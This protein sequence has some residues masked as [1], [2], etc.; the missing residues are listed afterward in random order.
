MTNNY[1]SS[2]LRRLGA[3]LALLPISVIA[4]GQTADLQIVKSGPATAAGGGAFSYTLVLDNNGPNAANNASF[5]DTL[6]PGVV[7]VSASCVAATNGASCPASIVADNSAVSGVL[8]TFPALGKVT[9]EILGNFAVSG[10]SSLTNTSTVS[11]PAGVTDPMPESNTS[12]VSTAMNYGA[13]LVVSKSQSAQSFV[14]G[15]TVT[16]VMTLT[17]NGPAAADGT[18]MEDFPYGNSGSSAARVNASYTFGGCSAVNG[19]VCP[20]TGAF[21]N[22]SGQ[23]GSAGYLFNTAVPRLPSGGAITITYTMVATAPSMCGLTAGA[24]QN[25]FQ[26]RGMPASVIDPDPTN[27]RAEVEQAVAATAACPEA[28]LEVTKTQSADDFVPGQP[29]TYVMTLTNNGPTAADGVLIEDFPYGYGGTAA[30]NVNAAY[31]FGSCV[32]ANGAV[33]PDAGAFQNYSGLVGSAGY[34]FNTSVP[35]LPSGGTITITYTMVADA[36]LRCGLPS[37][38]LQNV[39]QTRGLPP[40]VTDS[41]ASNN[42]AEVEQ[43]V[44]ATA[45]CPQA[46]LVATKTQSTDIFVAGQPVTYTMTLTNNGPAAADG[47]SML[48]FPY[49]YGAGVQ[50]NAAYSFAGCTATNGAV[51]PDNGVFQNYSGQ[52]GSAGYLFQ[53]TVPSLPSGGAVTITYTMVAN[54]TSACTSA[55]GTI[56]NNFRVSAPVGVTDPERFNDEILVE[57]PF[58]CADISTN[59]TVAPVTVQA[60]ETVTYTVSVVN[61]GPADVSNVAFSDPLPNGFVYA[62]ASCAVEVAPGTCGPVNYDAATRTVSSSIAAI[63]NGGQVRFTIV[64]TAGNIPGTYPNVA[65]AA[66]PSGVV[67]PVTSSNSS[68]VNLQ[69]FNTSAAV[70]VSKTITGL[71][72]SGLPAPLT[73]SGTVTCGA[74]A[75]QNWSATVAAGSSSASSA[76]LSFYDGDA[77]TVTENAPPAAPAGYVW[78]GTPVI[79]PSPTATLA[80]A[81]VAVSVTNALQRQT[82]SLDLSQLFTGPADGVAQVNGVFNFSLNCGA[83]GSYSLAITVTHGTSVPAVIS[84]LPAAASCTATATGPMPA[85]PGGFTWEASSYQNNPAVTIANGV[86]SIVVTTPLKATTGDVGGSV[87]AV[88]GLGNAMLVLMALLLL[89]FAAANVR[90]RQH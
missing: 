22:Y 51:C 55:N 26:T 83:D 36:P 7:N 60:G 80:S 18:M 48:D 89:G 58:V 77:C 28:D 5:L 75:P 82:G 53:T 86:V 65:Y 73:F 27:N 87:K 19:A 88:P 23:V 14:S 57:Q 41:N 61:A 78:T 4:W 32:A 68:S 34:L 2:L 11:P 54:M 69:I 49:A 12:S 17:N 35:A 43:T 25:V 42:R 46:D 59:K 71:S 81:P 29:V 13:D 85:A 31:S 20:D 52:V 62:S 3:I 45:D 47:A 6:P 8:P 15:Q 9:I 37:G 64:G 90:S 33:C 84:S 39:F 16:Y 38:P 1:F 74:Q 76:A 30:A 79:S 66:A 24:L 10:P 70:T 63:G 21:Q 40:G 72:P 67:D 56:Q 44:D 50:L